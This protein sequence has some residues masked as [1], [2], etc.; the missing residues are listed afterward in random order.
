[1]ENPFSEAQGWRESTIKI[2][3]PKEKKKVAESATPTMSIG[4]IYH[5]DLTDVITSAFK[6]SG[7]LSFNMTPF[8]QRWD[9]SDGKVVDIFSEA[10]T[11]ADFLEA[12]EEVNA[13]PR[14]PDDI[15]EQVVAS[16]MLWS[17][18]THLTNFGD[19]SMW[20]FYPFVDN[21]SKYTQGKPTANTCY[22]MAYIPN[23][24]QYTKS[25]GE[26]ATK[27][28][29]TH[30]KCELFQAV[31]ALLLDAKFMDAYCNGIIIQCADGIVHKV[32]PR[33]FSYSADYPEKVLLAG[34]KF[35]GKCPCPRCL[36]KKQDLA[37]MGMKRDM[38]QRVKK[39]RV[40]NEDHWRRIKFAWQLMFEKGV[41][42]GGKRVNAQLD[43]WSYV[44]TNYSS[45]Q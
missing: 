25:H 40:D 34:I 39:I 22:Y 18:S 3:L 7:S 4:V 44:S 43:K 38:R 35:L 42:V 12:H 33:F 10:Y 21:H 27:E 1:N 32:F 6:D 17:D 13:L 19:T 24:S 20:P 36:V 29:Y 2:T 23:A 15:L 41:S 5:R 16:L 30:C 11:S 37:K 14:N 28:T 9:M 8:T 45:P 31:W 26:P